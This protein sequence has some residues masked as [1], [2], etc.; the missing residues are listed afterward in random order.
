VGEEFFERGPKFFNYVQHIFPGRAKN[1]SGFLPL[2]SPGYGPEYAKY[3][4]FSSA[5]ST[6]F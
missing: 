5:Y 4:N 6:Y 3:S 2:R 1:S